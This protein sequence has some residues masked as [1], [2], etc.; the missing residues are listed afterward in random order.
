MKILEVR[1]KGIY[2]T[3]EFSLEEIGYLLDFLDKCEVKYDPGKE[4]DF[5]KSKEY[6]TKKFFPELDQ[7]NEDLKGK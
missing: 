7:L 2:I 4:K 5:V 1:P 6:V 3:M